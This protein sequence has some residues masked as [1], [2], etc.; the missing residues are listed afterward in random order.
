MHDDQ[1]REML[2]GLPSPAGDEA[3]TNGVLTRIEGEPG[4]V[5]SGAR[6]GAPAA[7]LVG[8]LLS[9]GLLAAG[10][11]AWTFTARAR[12]A[13]PEGDARSTL[14]ELRR[15]QQELA[16]RVQDLAALRSEPIYLG[17]SE[18]VD[19]VWRPLAHAEAEGEGR[20]TR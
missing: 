3:F 1:L 19:V 4:R 13:A 14:V 20:S 7:L 5:R 2:R 6:L 12:G 18:Q 8:V 16:R 15:E 9:A 17:G 10:L 11:R